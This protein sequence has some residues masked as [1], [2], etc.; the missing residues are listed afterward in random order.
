MK[1]QQKD[2]GSSGGVVPVITRVTADQH[3]HEL[4]DTYKLFHPVRDSSSGMLHSIAHVVAP[5]R[6]E[7]GRS[8]LLYIPLC[9]PVSLH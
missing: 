9:Q 5:C 7:C 2:S 1:Y 3:G 6:Q 8:W 4:S